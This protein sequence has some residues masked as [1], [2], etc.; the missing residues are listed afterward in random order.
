MPPA[1]KAEIQV[2]WVYLG[3]SEDNLDNLHPSLSVHM[4]HPDGHPQLDKGFG[5]GIGQRTLLNE[6]L[7]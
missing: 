7:V 2:L 4:F 6:A 5:H 3:L 1:R